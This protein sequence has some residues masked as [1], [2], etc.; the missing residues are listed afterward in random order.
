MGNL[1]DYHNDLRVSG[2]AQALSETYRKIRNTARYFRNLCNKGFN[3]NTDLMDISEL[4]EL[5]KW[6]I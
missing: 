4:S 6:A 5:D 2:D 3:P 1:L